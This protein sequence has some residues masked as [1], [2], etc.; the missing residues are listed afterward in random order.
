M[1][2]VPSG[3]CILA[4]TDFGAPD[5]RGSRDGSWPPDSTEDR[6]EREVG[7]FSD[8]YLK[9]ENLNYTDAG[10]QCFQFEGKV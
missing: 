9:K 10:N 4:G 7:T 5:S 8:M 2:F 1:D 3:R 6:P